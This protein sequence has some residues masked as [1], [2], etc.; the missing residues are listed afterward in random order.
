MP[1]RASTLESE[2]N[3]LQRHLPE[4]LRCHDNQAIQL[5]QR[6][7]VNAVTCMAAVLRPTLVGEDTVPSCKVSEL[8]SLQKNGSALRRVGPMK[9]AFLTFLRLTACPTLVA[10]SSLFTSLFNSGTKKNSCPSLEAMHAEAHLRN[11]STTIEKTTQT[12]SKLPTSYQFDEPHQLYF[13][14]TKINNNELANMR[15]NKK[16]A[17]PPSKTEPNPACVGKLTTTVNL[18]EREKC[19]PRCRHWIT[20][21]MKDEQR[22]TERLEGNKDRQIV[23]AVSLIH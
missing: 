11:K 22:T 16:R 18:T 9:I 3:P 19:D 8:P 7:G 12:S 6:T 17:E 5:H 13:A 21:G 23:V 20:A 4:K 10:A 15:C 14:K 2:A 1:S